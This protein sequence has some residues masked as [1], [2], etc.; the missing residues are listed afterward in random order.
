MKL[1]TLVLLLLT[2]ITACNDDD[3]PDLLPPTTQTGANTFGCRVNGEVWVPEVD[4]F[5]EMAIDAL[6]SPNGTLNMQCRKEPISDDRNQ[7]LQFSTV[8]DISGRETSPKY[9]FTYLRDR[10]VDGACRVIEL[11]TFTNHF[12]QITHID[13]VNYTISGRFEFQLKEDDCSTT[14][15]VTEGRFDVTYRQ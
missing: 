9:N 8:I 11:D 10:N 7:T 2:L 3:L 5:N 12:V 4:G 14:V 15:R 13:S 1:Y 6:L